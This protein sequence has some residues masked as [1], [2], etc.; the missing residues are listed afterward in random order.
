MVCLYWEFIP[1][2]AATR[3]GTGVDAFDRQVS[4]RLFVAGS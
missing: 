1:R 4:A 3:G 2:L